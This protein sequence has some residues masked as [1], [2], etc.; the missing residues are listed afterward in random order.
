MVDVAAQ[1]EN[2]LYRNLLVALSAVFLVVKWVEQTKVVEKESSSAGSNNMAFV[3]FQRM[4]VGIYLIM[5]TADWL[6][7]PTVYKL[8]QHYGF[9]H[10]QNG[11]LFIAG[12]GSSMIFGTFA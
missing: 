6:Q 11:Q 3:R 12:F 7:G 10:K 9:T 1:E 5:M 2:H 4:F 8:Y